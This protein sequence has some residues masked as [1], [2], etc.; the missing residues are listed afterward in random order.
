VIAVGG[1]GAP[2]IHDRWWCA[3]ASALEFGTSFNGVGISKSSKI[4]IMSPE[5]SK[6]AGAKLTANAGMGI[7]F[8]DG[9]RVI[10]DSFDVS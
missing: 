7:R 1:E 2:L 4:S 8:V 5:E 10:Y 6:Q 9:K 3:G